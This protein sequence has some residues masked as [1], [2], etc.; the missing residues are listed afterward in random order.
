MSKPDKV[1]FK[2]YWYSGGTSLIYLPY[3]S[4]GVSFFDEN[5]KNINSGNISLFHLMGKRIRLFNN[6]DSSSKYKL[7]LELYKKDSINKPLSIIRHIYTNDIITEIKLIDFEDSIKNLFGYSENEDDKV[8]ISITSDDKNLGFINISRYDTPLLSENQT[9]YLPKENFSM[10]TNDMLEA[11]TIK[12]INLL[13]PECAPLILEQNMDNQ[14][15]T[16]YWNIDCLNLDKNCYILVSD[17][18]SKINY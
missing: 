1:C 12:A 5:K 16:G 14:I 7:C 4:V 2:I 11:T 17:K 9:V 13:D 6:L 15:C 3:P 8:K 10:Y 18:K